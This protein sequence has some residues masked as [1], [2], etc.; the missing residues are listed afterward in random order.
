MLER[1]HDPLEPRVGRELDVGAV[2]EEH[3]HRDVVGVRHLHVRL[4]GVDVVARVRM[5][6]ADAVLA[7]RR[8]PRAHA[9]VGEMLADAGALDETDVVA[10]IIADRQ[11]RILRVQE[12]VVPDDRTLAGHLT[13]AHAGRFRFREKPV[14]AERAMEA[15]VRVGAVHA[16]VVAAVRS[17]GAT[18]KWRRRQKCRGHRVGRAARCSCLPAHSLPDRF[19]SSSSRRRMRRRGRSAARR[20]RSESASPLLGQ[21]DAAAE[22]QQHL[23]F[24]RREAIVAE[25]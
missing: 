17:I 11:Q 2:L 21:P 15:E 24:G 5:Q 3:A 6:F 8:R 12:V 16:V 14:D 9:E 13:V 19:G 22:E 20:R 18:G 1:R 10:E 25:P 4:V 7:Q 23:L